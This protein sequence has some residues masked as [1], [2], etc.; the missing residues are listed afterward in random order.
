MVASTY[1]GKVHKDRDSIV[2]IAFVVLISAAVAVAVGVWT[3]QV[4]REVPVMSGPK[5]ELPDVSKIQVAFEPNVGQAEPAAAFVA[6]APGATITFAPSRVAVG[7]GF[8]QPRQV[9]VEF[10]GSNPGAAITGVGE[11]TAK[12][13]YLTGND[14]AKWRMGVPTYSGI[15]YA[16]L[17]PGVD[18][19]YEGTG[20]SLKG[21]YTVAPG[22]DPSAIVWQYAG[23]EQ[24]SV[25][26]QGNLQVQAAGAALTEQAPVAWQETGDARTPVSVSYSVAADRSIS[27][28][29]GGYDPA[30][31]LVID[32]T[33]TYSTFL[34]GT[35]GEDG[36]GIAVDPQG[37]MYVTGNTLSANFPLVAPYQGTFGGVR[38]A[39]VAKF[40]AAGNALIYSTYLGGSA[41]DYARA[42]AVDSAGNAYIAGHTT[43][44]N[45][46][47]VN[48]YDPTF[49]GN[50]EAFVTK[51]N[52]S[53]QPVYSTYL[54]GSCA[55]TAWGI[56]VGGDGSAYVTGMTCTGTFPVLNAYQPNYAGSN[57][58]FLTK[59]NPA[60]N[61]LVYSTFLGRGN[62]DR[63]YAVAADGTGAAYVV[64]QTT[65]TNFVT[66]NPFQ[67][68]F[69]GGTHDAFI[70]KFN[71]AG[72]ALV[73]SSF[74][75][76]NGPT[77]EVALSVA[78]DGAGSAYITGKTGSAN[79]PV[80]Q[81]IDGS[82]GGPQDAFITKVNPTGGS[83]AYS[84][85]LGG[86]ASEDGNGIAVDAAGNAYVVGFTE[87]NDFPQINYIQNGGQNDAFVTKVNAAGNAWAYSTYLGGCCD[88]MAFGVTVDTVGNAY[89]TGGT[90][91]Q[92]FPVVN[93]YQAVDPGH[94]V[95]VSRIYEGIVV[96]TPT[97][98]QTVS[99]A[100]STPTATNT[101]IAS[102]TATR[103]S[104]SIVTPTATRTGTA[105]AATATAT[106]PTATTGTSTP[107]RTAG[108]Q[109]S[110]TPTPTSCA[111]SFSDVP[112]GSTFYP[113]VQALACRGYINGYPD[114]TFRPGLAV[115]RGQLSK[116]VANAALFSEPHTNQTFQ[117]VPV[118]HTF[119]IYIQRLASRGIIGGYM[120]G[121]PGEP[122]IPPNNRPYFRPGNNVTRGQASKIVAMSKGLP[123][124]PQ[125]QWTFQDVPAYNVFWASVESLSAAGAIN[126]YACGGVGEP[127]VE[128]ENRPYFRWG[129]SVS[130]GQTCK[131]VAVVFFPEGE[132]GR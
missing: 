18:L 117:D 114:G 105:A 79:F 17:Y 121:A 49:G 108:P 72:S 21:T 101:A 104:T 73:Y 14:P 119:Y 76:G 45:F 64:G 106:S 8:E 86:T 96:T 88:D 71:A 46:P 3:A 128:P 99:V 111:V 58:A 132:P 1:H 9:A 107:T 74:L 75:G 127:C 124:P 65:S 43:S 11:T 20:G 84:T 115:T 67:P 130:R 59:F 112:P 31:A 51:L 63:G 42:I 10:V 47:V 116:V 13:N 113:Y 61:A 55:D 23:A 120:C 91:S 129:A 62:T 81:P 110:S 27:F 37:N 40:N 32:P 6:R 57:D 7:L 4:R 50:E 34:G 38:D 5:V 60:G 85:F 12:V 29:L 41:A 44:T 123:A 66:L 89:I 82:L 26:A 54:G 30:R 15:N 100:T 39:F 87:S 25:D 109:L 77:A 48:A 83:L 28:A 122:C 94:T 90:G 16:G 22:A 69:G 97:P 56:A 125:G 52:A 24:V 78:A 131:I 68:T 93:P 92:D 118:T 70:T 98:V 35:D 103:T 19:R 36:T 102:V 2:W 80:A 126:G 95:F 33:L 53:G